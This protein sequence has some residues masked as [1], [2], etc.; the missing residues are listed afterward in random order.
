MAL[1]SSQGIILNC[2]DS[3]LPGR[4]GNMVTLALVWR[5]SYTKLLCGLCWL[6]CHD[7]LT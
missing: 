1:N 4:M 7:L 6:T 3:N 2:P 5:A